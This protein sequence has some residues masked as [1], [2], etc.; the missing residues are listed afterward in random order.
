[1]TTTR[2]GFLGF[3]GLA[4]LLVLGVKK[5]ELRADT[6]Y[7][8]RGFGTRVEPKDAYA[9]EMLREV[10]DWLEESEHVTPDWLRPSRML[11]MRRS[12]WLVL[13]KRKD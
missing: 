11:K 13:Y 10:L 1:M 12:H 4:P 9:P 6:A 7:E 8:E 2:R 3:L 5:G